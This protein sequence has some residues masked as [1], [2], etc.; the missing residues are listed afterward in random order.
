MPALYFTYS[1]LH[2]YSFAETQ[3]SWGWRKWGDNF[4]LDPMGKCAERLLL[5]SAATDYTIFTP[6]IVFRQVHALGKNQCRRLFECKVIKGHSIL[7]NSQW[8]LMCKSDFHES[9]WN[10][11]EWT[12]ISDIFIGKKSQKFSFFR[13]WVIWGQSRGNTWFSRLLMVIAQIRKNENLRCIWLID[14]L[15]QVYRLA[16][17]SARNMLVTLGPNFSS[18]S[19]QNRE[20]F[21]PL[22]LACL[23]R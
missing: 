9:A 19:C 17:V 6:Y 22:L 7:Y 16:L 15:S 4:A 13:C 8:R 14:C 23:T 12:D 1:C 11:A 10:C 18:I 5:R 21:E 20:K 2:M 3:S